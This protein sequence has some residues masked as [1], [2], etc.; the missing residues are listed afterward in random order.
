MLCNKRGIEPILSGI[1]EARHIPVDD[2][3]YV[4]EIGLIKAKP[5]IRIS[6]KI[7]NEIIPRELI[8]TSE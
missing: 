7:Y 8:R 4:A 6:N 2:L 1:S 5:Q 3:D